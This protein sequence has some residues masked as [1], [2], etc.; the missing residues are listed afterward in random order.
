MKKRGELVSTNN[1]R[2]ARLKNYL[3]ATRFLC[4]S[5]DDVLYILDLSLE[6]IFFADKIDEKYNLPPM[7]NGS[8]TLEE[9]RGIL[10][11][12]DAK[13]IEEFLK[14]PQDW[15]DRVY[16]RELRFINCDGE[17][18]RIR[19][20]GKMQNDN[21][22]KPQWLIG[23]IADA[24]AGESADPLTGLPDAKRLTEDLSE[25]L[26]RQERVF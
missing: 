15:G 17:R 2:T 22:G 8:Y 19:S 21:A 11:E 23:R 13:E 26:E 20:W 18:I 14:H 10:H 5:A 25:C 3:D 16:S 24:R 7:K 1:E 9:M 4:N 12:K 6:K